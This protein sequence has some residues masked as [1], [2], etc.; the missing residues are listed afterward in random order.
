MD[1]SETSIIG[2]PSGPILSGPINETF[3]NAAVKESNLINKVE[4]CYTAAL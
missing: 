2:A 3:I 1:Y 4:A